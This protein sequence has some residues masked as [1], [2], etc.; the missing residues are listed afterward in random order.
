MKIANRP[1]RIL[2]ISY[3]FHPSIGGI[4][5]V[6]RFLADHLVRR[7]LDIEVVTNSPG[8]AG[9]DE[10]YTYPVIRRPSHS[11]LLRLVRR[12]DLVYQNNISLNYLWPLLLAPRPLVITHQTPIDET[13]E[14]S[15]LKRWLKVQVMRFASCTSCSQ[16]L[17]DTFPVPSR[18]IYNPLRAGIFHLNSEV[19]RDRE[20][21]FVGRLSQSKG[22]D[23]LLRALSLLGRKGP[24]PEITIIGG[25]P[26]E[27]KLKALA[28][29]LELDEQVNFI[30]P[31]QGPE[32]A[33]HLNQH[34]IM[35]VP[36]RRK[37]AEAL[38]IVAM[39]GIACGAVPI[40]AAQ[41]GLPE[42]IG[43]CGL[44][45]ECENPQS[46]ADTLELALA[47]PEL[48]DELRRPA[49]DFLRLFDEET[50]VEQYL[51]VFAKAMPSGKL[52]YRS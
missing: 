12:S 6:S 19:K 7:G 24:K 20:L 33:H 29:E 15:R 18:V 22:I 39:E 9:R 10:G 42:A 5:T 1:T 14:R 45:F 48:R 28:T 36:S 52:S 46:L 23:T 50:I 44:T 26:E 31:L 8:I 51:E 41:G 43:P 25:G 34:Q 4:E 35:V 27:Q 32:I 17:A 49:A 40:V 16:F 30:G 13:I 21:V 47:N 11:E 3:A 38:G 37:P 2:F